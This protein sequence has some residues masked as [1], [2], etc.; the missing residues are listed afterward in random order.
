M[1][2]HRLRNGELFT[3]TEEKVCFGKMGSD[4]TAIEP[5]VNDSQCVRSVQTAQRV[6]EWA[7]T[8]KACARPM[9]D[10]KVGRLLHC[11]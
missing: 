2:A 9:P 3:F 7:Y 5:F 6:K 1:A 11:S 4:E 8:L 10:N